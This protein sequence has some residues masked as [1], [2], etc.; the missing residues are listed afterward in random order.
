MTEVLSHGGR[1]GAQRLSCDRAHTVL[2]AATSIGRSAEEAHRTDRDNG[3]KGSEAEARAQG[4][5]ERP[6]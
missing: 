4:G 6:C 1:G 5:L 2:K 3:Q